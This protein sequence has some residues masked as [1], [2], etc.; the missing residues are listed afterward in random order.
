MFYIMNNVDNER[1]CNSVGYFFVF[2]P[3]ALLKL[4]AD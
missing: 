3:Q 2:L 1:Q 4:T